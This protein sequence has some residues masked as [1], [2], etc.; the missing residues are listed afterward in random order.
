METVF[1]LF[2]TLDGQSLMLY[3]GTWP[4]RHECEQH[5]VATFILEQGFYVVPYCKPVKEA[6]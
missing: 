1:A 2:L 4:T 6:P 5:A 3:P